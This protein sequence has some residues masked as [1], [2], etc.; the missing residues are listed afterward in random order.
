MKSALSL[1]FALVFVLSVEASDSLDGVH[2]VIEHRKMKAARAMPIRQISEN[3]SILSLYADGSI[4]TQ[5]VRVIRMTET[6]KA[7]VESKLQDEA[8]LD[9]AKALATRIKN[10]HSAK[11]KGLSDADVVASAEAVF[12]N[13][14]SSATKTIIA[15]LLAAGAVAVTKT[16]K[17]K[18]DK[19]S[20]S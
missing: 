3:G 5:A 6:T 2:A 14:T 17:T 11:V 1:I 20:N 18:N 15:A 4:T 13:S 7:A 19:E 12:D 8:L 16:K 9:S 10:T